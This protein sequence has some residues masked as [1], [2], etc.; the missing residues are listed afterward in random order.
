MPSGGLRNPGLPTQIR[1]DPRFIDG[2]Q[3]NYLGTAALK[4][5]SCGS[6]GSKIAMHLGRAGFGAMTFVDNESMS[7]HNAARHALIEQVSVL[8]PPRKATNILLT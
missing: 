2:G 1:R 4:K 6:L 8:L 5:S 3:M 7:P